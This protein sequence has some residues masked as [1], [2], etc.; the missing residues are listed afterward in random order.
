MTKK[1]PFLSLF[2]LLFLNSISNQ[3]IKR[4][5]KGILDHK[6]P[7]VIIVFYRKSVLQEQWAVIYLIRRKHGFYGL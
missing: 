4:D 7:H 3:Q 2:F 1:R 5:K 6:N